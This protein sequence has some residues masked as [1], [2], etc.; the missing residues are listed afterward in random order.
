MGS[1][2]QLMS[3]S[4]MIAVTSMR[5]FVALLIIFSLITPSFAVAQEATE[6]SDLFT[7]TPSPQITYSLPYPGILPGHPL[8]GIKMLRDRIV[9]FLITDPYKKAEFNL[10]QADKR[11]NAGLYLLEQ[12]DKQSDLAFSTISKGENYFSQSLAGVDA[13][14]R[15]GR[16]IGAILGDLKQSAMKHKDVISKLS[17]EHPDRKKEID[18]LLKQIISFQNQISQLE[19]R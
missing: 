13:M 9:L 1:L 19:K 7:P 10:L 11:L 3:N 14:Q 18:G 2:L 6:S 8:Y 12:G 5:F 4:S 15:E 16:D 17:T